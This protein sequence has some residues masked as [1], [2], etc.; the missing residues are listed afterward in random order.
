MSGR[1]TIRLHQICITCGCLMLASAML[2]MVVWQISLHVTTEKARR[3]T[4][5]ILQL[6][7][8]PQSA[9][10]ESRSNN[11]MASLAV[12]GTDYIGLL[13]FPMFDSILPVR[14]EWNKGLPAPCWYDGSVYDG[15]LIIGTSNQKG[16]Y[17]F[18]QEINVRD[19]LYFTDMTGNR[20]TY[21]VT[22]VRYREHADD[23]IL[24]NT[25]ADLTLFIKNMYALEYI[26]LY[27]NT[28][29]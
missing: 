9:V 1:K 22:D 10:P 15:S 20:Y 5:T 2:L 19:V 3:D 27:C 25:E 6:I 7:P 4:E 14:A 13:S 28:P 24:R 26:I 18:C 17:T 11:T 12:D 8:E 29:E 21:E 23:Q 16:Q